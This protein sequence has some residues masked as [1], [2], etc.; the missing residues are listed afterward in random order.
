MRASGAKSNESKT[1]GLSLGPNKMEIP[2]WIHTKLQVKI[3]GVMFLSS[4]RDTIRQNWE[5][6][7]NNIRQVLQGNRYRALNLLQRVEFVN[8]YALSKA[9]YLSQLLP[10]PQIIAQ[11]IRSATGWFIWQGH[12]LRISRPQLILP[13]IRGGLNLIDPGIKANCLYLKKNLQHLTG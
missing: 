11:K 1:V 7:T 13:K 8:I 6:V 5:T 9:W 12:I 4:L 10:M 2:H 3:L